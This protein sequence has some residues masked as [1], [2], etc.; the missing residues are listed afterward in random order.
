VIERAL[1]ERAAVALQLGPGIRVDG[2]A[3]RQVTVTTEVIPCPPDQA[4]TVKAR[5]L[6][7]L[8]S[9][10]HALTGGPAGTGWPLG[11]DVFESEVAQVLSNVPG[12]AGVRSIRLSSAAAAQRVRLTSAVQAG[13]R[14]PAGTSVTHST[15]RMVWTLDEPLPAG[16]RIDELVV[17]WLTEGDRVHV[18]ADGTVVGRQPS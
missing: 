12:V 10:I 16:S 3:Y 7:A 13:L 8:G 15:G 11:R 6:D 5:A 4:E 1:D 2:P 9:F 17:R 14:I 18:V